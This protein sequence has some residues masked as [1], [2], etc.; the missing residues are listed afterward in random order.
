METYLKLSFNTDENASWAIEFLET[1]K[2]TKLPYS[3]KDE[4]W[5]GIVEQTVALTKVI[6]KIGTRTEVIPEWDSGN[7][8]SVDCPSTG[9]A[10]NKLPIIL[11]PL[12]V[13]AAT[14][15]KLGSVVIPKV[16]TRGIPAGTIDILESIEYQADISLDRYVEIIKDKD[17]GFSNI[18]PTD[19]LAPIDALLMKQA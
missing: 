11:P 18:A 16:S 3:N 13:E 6:S 9:G 14:F 2:N 7:F 12:V 1:I 17:I 5:R 8:I 19:E 4:N 15:G 10:G